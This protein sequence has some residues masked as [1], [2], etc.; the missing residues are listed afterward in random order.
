MIVQWEEKD[1]RCGRGLWKAGPSEQWIIGY[2]PAVEKDDPDGRFL[3]ISTSDGMAIRKTPAQL[4]AMLNEGKY[5]PIEIK[6]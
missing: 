1:L 4:V 3:L 5:L 2:L 6:S